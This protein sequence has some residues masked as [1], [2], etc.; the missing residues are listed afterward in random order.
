M[1]TATPEQQRQLLDLQAVDTNLRQL[2]HRRSHLPEQVALDEHNATLDAVASEYSRSR[3]EMSKLQLRQ[4][5]LENDIATLDARRKSEEGRMYSGMIHSEKEL[6]ALRHELGSLKSRKSDL[7]DE[8]LEVMERLEELEGMAASL[9]QRHGDLERDRP[10]L[11]TTRDE[12]ATDIDAELAET[13]GRRKELFEALP[14][15]VVA[16]YTDLLQRKQ[17]LAVAELSGTTCNG[18]RLQLTAS[19]MEEVRRDAKRYLALCPQ[20]GRGVVPT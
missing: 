7:E 1:I 5:R 2:Q 17:G 13:D 10:T 3:D 15:A 4:R 6:E 8:L 18:C 16:A 9:K 11:T 14:D 19:E 12:A 20:C